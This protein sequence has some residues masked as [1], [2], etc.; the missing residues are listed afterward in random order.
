VGCGRFEDILIIWES[1]LDGIDLSSIANE[2]NER[3]KRLNG[4]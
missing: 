2:I 4:K 3:F 1:D